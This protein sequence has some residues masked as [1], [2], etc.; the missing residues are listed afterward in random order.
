M[1]FNEISEKEETIILSKNYGIKNLKNS[2]I[3]PNEC[4]SSWRKIGGS[5]LAKI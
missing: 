5:E 4:E 2:D 1:N 3:F